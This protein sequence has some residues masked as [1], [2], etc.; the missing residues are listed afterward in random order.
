MNETPRPTAD[1]PFEKPR[2]SMTVL[3][4]I[5]VCGAIGA[6]FWFGMPKLSAVPSLFSTSTPTATTTSP[7]TS[8]PTST[9]TD[10]S[11]ATPTV[12]YTPRPTPT[13]TPDERVQNPANQHLYLYVKQGKTWHEARDYCTSLDGHLVTIQAPSENKFVYNLATENTQAGTWLGATDEDQE[14]TW[15]WVT[16]EPRSYWNWGEYWNYLGVGSTRDFLAFDGWDK[17]WYDQPDSNMYFVCEWESIS[18]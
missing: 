8:P 6:L 7:P 16:G 11:T 13:A 3:G 4:I 18:P 15:V 1:E 5:L 14:G 9:P 17:T 12:T 2:I 10:T